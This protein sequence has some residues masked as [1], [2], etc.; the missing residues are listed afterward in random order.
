MALN[1][2][3]IRQLA[4][5]LVANQKSYD[6]YWFGRITDCGT[7][8]CLAG[9]CLARKL[10]TRKYRKLVKEWPDTWSGRGVCEKAGA[11][12][13]GLLS[14][15]PHPDLPMIFRE[16]HFWPGDLQEQYES[17]GPRWRVIAAL[18]ALQR[19]LPNGDIDQNPEAVHTR[20]PQLTKLLKLKT[21]K[22]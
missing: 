4:D 17:D 12:Q 21:T 1:K 13:L 5:D 16:I 8:S 7:V 22:N 14:E 20:L 15:V 18:K 11:E 3:G 19:L 6:Q 2:K 9:T 10:G